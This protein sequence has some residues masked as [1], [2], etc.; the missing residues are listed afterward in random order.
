M[1][2]IYIISGIVGVVM[3]MVAAISGGDQDSGLDADHG[4]GLDGDGGLDIGGADHGVDPGAHEAWL[5][6]FSLR[7]WTFFL[8]G[9]GLTGALLTFLT[10]LHPGFIPW[11]S[12]GVGLVCGVVVASL[13]RVLMRSETN[14]GASI[15]DLL[16]AQGEV[17]V[18]VRH[19]TPGRIRCSIK[20]ELIDFLA[21]AQDEAELTPGESVV[22]ISIEDNRATVIPSAALLA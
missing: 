4:G 22:I 1:L 7:F 19:D 20:G 5:P 9:F 21:V 18:T 15:N 17:L 10:G 3:A 12:V 8:G 11:V 13:M 2:A 6:F 16:G 14:S